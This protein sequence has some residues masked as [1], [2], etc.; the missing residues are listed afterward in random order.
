MAKKE[1]IWDLSQL[2]ENTNAASIQKKL[3]AMVA[4]AEEVR[5]KYHGKIVALTVEGLLELL[6]LKDAYRL[7]FEGVVKY[8]RLFVYCTLLIQLTTLLSN[9]TMVRVGRI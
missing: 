5:K 1:M 8:C 3:E 6:E 9:L 2:V 4:K 7:E